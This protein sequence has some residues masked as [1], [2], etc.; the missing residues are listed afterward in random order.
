MFARARA[1][2]SRSLSTRAISSRRRSS[3]CACK[4]CRF[5]CCF[6]R[7]EMDFLPGPA[8]GVSRG[9]K[10]QVED[11]QHRRLDLVPAADQGSQ[12]GEKLFELERLGEIIVGPEVE[13]LDLVV[14]RPARGKN[15]NVR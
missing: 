4:S 14:E 15:Q 12:A 5:V 1:W 6:S 10:L 7:R 2:T 13:A 3:Y 8:D 11:L 9:V